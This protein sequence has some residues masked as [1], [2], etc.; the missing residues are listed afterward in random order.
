MA[1]AGLKVE[2]TGDKSRLDRTIAAVETRMGRF[3]SRIGTGLG[4]TFLKLSAGF[5][6]I[7]AGRAIYNQLEQTAEWVD[8]LYDMSVQTGVAASELMKLEA[9]FAVAG[10]G[11]TDASRLLSVFIGNLREA[12]E[13]PSQSREALND[14]GFLAPDFKDKGPLEA[15]DMVSKRVQELNMSIPQITRLVEKLFGARMGYQ[16]IRLMRDPAMF[17]SIKQQVSAL[18]EQIDGT[19]ETIAK[20]T[21]DWALAKMK[22]RGL[23]V[24]ILSGLNIS[25]TIQSL[26]NIDWSGI[27][28]AL[29]KTMGVLTQL[30]STGNMTAFLGDFL[31]DLGDV[32]KTAADYIAASVGSAI[33]KAIPGIKDTEVPMSF[34]E[35]LRQNLPSGNFRTSRNIEATLQSIDTSTASTAKSLSRLSMEA[36]FA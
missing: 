27:G 12:Q 22:M 6:A 25:G 31:R 35:M 30:L 5:A 19:G 9:A 23:S 18:G 2:I 33:T 4:R 28:V 1:R 34:G 24:G 3:A 32:F 17:E 26:G 15:F 14:L 13:G 11:I 20:F 10:I 36:K 8:G 16:M 21:D 7:F 29:G